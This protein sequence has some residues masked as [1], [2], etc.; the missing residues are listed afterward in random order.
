MRCGDSFEEAN[1]SREIPGEGET[2][3]L[4]TVVEPGIHPSFPGVITWSP[5]EFNAS[6]PRTAWR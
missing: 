1:L 5:L 2:K 6:V 4:E 3:A